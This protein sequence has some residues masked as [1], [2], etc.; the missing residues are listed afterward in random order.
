MLA[1]LLGDIPQT[2]LND[3]FQREAVFIDNGLYS[4]YT[5]LGKGGRLLKPHQLDVSKEEEA[6]QEPT[7]RYEPLSQES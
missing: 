2:F 7:F 4:Y 3:D 6:A 1:T 5:T